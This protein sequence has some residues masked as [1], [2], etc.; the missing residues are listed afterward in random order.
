MMSEWLA[1]AITGS[2]AYLRRRRR[3]RPR[4]TAGIIPRIGAGRKLRTFVPAGRLAGL[5]L[6]ILPQNGVDS[7]SLVAV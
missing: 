6:M 4:I 7:R 1:L 2:H 3:Q 5:L